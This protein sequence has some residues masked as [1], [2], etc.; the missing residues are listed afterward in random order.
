VTLGLVLRSEGVIGACRSTER[1]HQ[2]EQQICG[3]VKKDNNQSQT[4]INAVIRKFK[5]TRN[6]WVD[7]EKNGGEPGAVEGQAWCDG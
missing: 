1:D 2:A 6:G 3:Y 7:E 5:H 4:A